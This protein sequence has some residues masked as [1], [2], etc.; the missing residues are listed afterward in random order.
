MTQERVPVRRLVG[1]LAVAVACLSAPA[2]AQASDLP[3]ERADHSVAASAASPFVGL[4]VPVRLLDTRKGVG[5]PAGQVPARSGIQVQV[6][7]RLGIPATGVTAIVAN[8]TVV[9]PAA[10]GYVTAYPAGTTRPNTSNLNHTTGSVIANHAVIRL[11]STGAVSL[12]TSSRTDLLLDVSGYFTAT[13]GYTPVSPAR[14][15]DTRTGSAVSAGTSV[16][17]VVA[18]RAGVPASGVRAVVLNV[19]AAQAAG[20]GYLTVHPTG[21][22]PP[23]V[24]NVNYVAGETRATMVQ[25]QP[26]PSGSVTVRTSATADIL[27]DVF[28]WISDT[29]DYHPVPPQRLLDTRYGWGSRG[30]NTLELAGVAGVPSTGAYAVVVGAAAVTPPEAGWLQVYPDLNNQPHTSTLNFPAGRS[31][32]NSATSRLSPS[33]YPGRISV[34]PSVATHTIVDVFGYYAPP[35][36]RSV[37]VEEVRC[38]AGGDAQYT[39]TVAPPHRALILQAAAFSP[40][41]LI[42]TNLESAGPTTAD[43]LTVTV[44]KT[45]LDQVRQQM[46]KPQLFAFVQEAPATAGDPYESI[47]RTPFFPLSVLANRC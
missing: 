31:V 30:G 14:L 36:A 2:G 4:N 37:T 13:S 42:S 7:G 23:S 27:V 39:V 35:S 34:Y 43:T 18:G 12:W 41:D 24:S 46:T 19:T 28:G 10:A 15:L 1:A 16:D 44:P 32:S 8:V 20:G 5:A 47:N 26:G 11:G 22:A 6:S 40:G 21:T 29:S 38:V 9:K 17:V 25:I 33:S 45:T 3:P